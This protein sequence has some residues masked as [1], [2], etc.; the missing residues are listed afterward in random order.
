MD[1]AEGAD[2]VMVKPG[3]PYLDIVRRV[4]ETFK[5]PTF[6]YQV[7]GEYAMIKAAVEKGFMDHDRAVFETLLAFKRAGASG[8][9]TYFAKH[10][11]QQLK[12]VRINSLP[13]LFKSLQAKGKFVVLSAEDGG[14]DVGLIDA[15][16]NDL[17]ALKGIDPGGNWEADETEWPFADIRLVQFDDSYSRTLQ[18]YAEKQAQA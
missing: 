5:M 12:A 16:E 10:V 15:I 7:S 1:I 4:S 13:T 18:R 11:A 3:L 2:M 9:L 14:A 8:I 6:V 17:I